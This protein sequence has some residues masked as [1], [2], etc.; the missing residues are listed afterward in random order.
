[1]PTTSLDH[2]S[3]LCQSSTRILDPGA[4][5]SYLW[6]DG[7]TSRK[8]TVS[9]TGNYF[10]KVTDNNGCINWD[11]VHIT[12]ILPSPSNFLPADTSI[13]SYG[14]AD[15]TSAR[16][17]A[18]YIWNNGN[19]SPKLIVDKAG[20]YWVQ[21]R[22]SKGCIG[23]DTILVNIKDCMVGLKVPNAFTPNHDA[24]ND[25]FRALLFGNVKSFELTVYNRWGQIVFY[26]TDRYKG[27]DGTIGGKEQD[28]GVFIWMCKYELE[29]DQQKV[30]RGTVTLI[31]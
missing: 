10:V 14:T 9:K 23:A 5:S 30:E 21:V 1:L 22:D 11:T 6:Q 24:T 3:E 26:T 31:R 28:P 29:G 13:C 19:T 15:L 18:S 25:V 2:N 27:W 7:S 17:F 16:S 12:T 20:T 8:Y 4:F